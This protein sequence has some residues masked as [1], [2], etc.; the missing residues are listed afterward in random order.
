MGMESARH[1]RIDQE[2]A[3]Q[4]AAK[5]AEA[6]ANAANQQQTD[7][8]KARQLLVSGG[9]NKLVTSGSLNG[10]TFND[11]ARRKLLGG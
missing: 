6:A 2:I 3:Q 8:E 10:T 11:S 5:A 9:A 7:D 1:A 4:Q